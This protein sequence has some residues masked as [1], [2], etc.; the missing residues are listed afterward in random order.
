MAE[1][2]RKR[3]GDRLLEGI[4]RESEQEAQRI[5]DEA[6]RQAREIVENARKKADAI[7]QEAREK[8]ERQAEI[9]RKKNTQNIQAEQRKRR[10][11]AQE[12][13][14]NL[15][16][17]K[18]RDSLQAFIGEPEYSEILR[19]W[20]AEA[21]IGLGQDEL[22]VNSSA[23]ERKILTDSLVKKA[24]KDIAEQ[25]GRQVKIRVS[26]DPPLQKQGVFLSTPDGRLA[27]NNLV[28]ARLQR[29]SAG[30]R[31]MVYGRIRSEDQ[32]K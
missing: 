26:D 14:F 29:Y 19:G 12:E 27:F 22:I 3:Q 2:K 24:E 32:G 5:M 17:K 10:L 21:A 15:A 28:E 1:N 6:E 13:L 20:I 30:I 9:L 8:G 11:K 16:V 31:K 25:T 4:N 7:R 18:I 23:A